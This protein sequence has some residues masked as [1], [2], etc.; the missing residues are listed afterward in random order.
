MTTTHSHVHVETEERFYINY[1]SL[2][3]F[4]VR[5]LQTFSHSRK[6][7]AEKN[8]EIS[9][10]REFTFHNDSPFEVLCIFARKLTLHANNY[11]E[12]E[13]KF[14]VIIHLSIKF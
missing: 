7:T 3:R 5:Y 6:L 9:N 8:S 12:T 1:H 13:E 14:Y 4:C 2:I 10:L 11:V